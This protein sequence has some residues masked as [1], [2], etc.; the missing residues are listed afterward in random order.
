MKT[1]RTLFYLLLA[2]NIALG[3]LIALPQIGIQLPWTPTGEGRQLDQLSPEKI[4]LLG[5]AVPP[6]PEAPQ[7]QPATSTQTT[8]AG[9]SPTDPNTLVCAGLRNLTLED[10]QQLSDAATR[11]G[12]GV[13]VQ[14]S[15]LSPT[16]YWVNIP[17]N[18]GKEGASKRA[19]VLTKVGIDDYI[20]VRDAG[21]T[22][23]A[24]S[25]GLFRS[26]E[27]ARRLV[28]ALRKKN[29][30]SAQVTLRDNTG[31]NAHADITGKPAQ[32]EALL[33]DYLSDHKDA[34]RDKCGSASN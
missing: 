31:N 8:A 13:T 30:K 7:S 17:P 11:Q 6:Q 14:I 16:S 20:I 4:Q 34:Q 3:L 33:K 10:T 22:Q 27:A 19:E 12:E 2:T 28:E 18:G 24:I 25:L 9:A 5:N 29:I 32:L 26:E 1:A 21:P 23:Y 15:G